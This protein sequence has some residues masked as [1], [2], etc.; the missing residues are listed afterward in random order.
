MERVVEL[1]DQGI[2]T[3]DVDDRTDFINKRGA[4]LL[5]HAPEDMIGRPTFDLL[6]LDVVE[7]WKLRISQAKE[8][9]A[10]RFDLIIRRNDGSIVWTSGTMQ[11][12]YGDDGSYDGAL[13]MFSDITERKAAENSLLESERLYRGLY[14]SFGVG[15]LIGKLLYDEH[16]TPNDFVFHAINPAYESQTG[17]TADR[18]IGKKASQI[19]SHIEPIWIETIGEAVR[20]QRAMS[21]EDY[22]ASLDMWFKGSAS[23]LPGKDLFAI[24]F[25]DVTDRKRTMEALKASEAKYHTLFET[26]HEGLV[27]LDVLRDGDGNATDVRVIEVN[28][29]FEQQSGMK[30]DQLL[31]KK[32]FEVFPRSDAERWMAILKR[33]ADTNEAEVVTEY[34]ELAD[35][36]FE[37]SVYPRGR[38]RMII[39]Y[40][41]IS[42]RKRAEAALK[43]REQLYRTLF[44]N[45]EDAF[46]L[47]EMIYDAHGECVDYWILELNKAW[48]GQTGLKAAD[49]VNKRV[50]ERMPGLEP[51]WYQI[52]GGVARTGISQRFESFNQASGRWYETY[53][54]KYQEDRTGVLFRDITERKRVEKQLAFQADLLDNVHDPLTATDEDFTIT[55]WNRA[56]EVMFGWSAQE[57]VGKVSKDIF[58]TRVPSSSRRDAIEKMLKENGYEGEVYYRRKDGTY[59]LAQARATVLRGPNGEF[60]GTI[61]SFSDITERKKAENALKE[62]EEKYRSLF[63]NMTEMFQILEPIYD[64]SGNVNDFRYIEVNTASETLSRIKKEKMEGRTSKELWGVVEDYWFE[65]LERVLRAGEPEHM[66]NYSRELDAYYDLHAWKASE[67]RVAILFSNI[68]DVKRAQRQVGEERAR[69]Q[70]TLDSLP[71]GVWI[72]DKEGKMVLINEKASQ[73]WGGVAPAATIV[74]EYGAYE[75]W[76]PETRERIEAEDMPLAHAIKGE[77]VRERLLDFERFDGTGGTQVVSASP[78]LDS[79]GRMIGAIAVVQDITKMKDLE[80]D[81]SK[82]N[83]E[84]RRSNAELQQFAYVASHDMQEPLRMVTNYLSLIEKRHGGELTPKVKEYVDIASRS[85]E[86]MRQLV[87]DLLQY[88]R[89]DTQG[90]AFTRVDMN[91]V[92][93]STLM[94][95]KDAV[96]D[97]HATYAIDPLPTV[98]GDELQ[99]KQVMMN[100]ISNAIKFHD[101]SDPRFE[102]SAFKYGTEHVIAVQDNGIGID[103]RFNDKLFHMFSRLHTRD[104]YPG[105]GIGLAISKKIVE[106]HGGRIWVESEVGKGST[107]YFTIP[108][109]G[110]GPGP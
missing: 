6:P 81:L 78:I 55:Y 15:I 74:D 17:F 46:A 77:V 79:K 23:P 11:P 69:L 42:E 9:K 52:Y 103:L 50:S 8:G 26:M 99:L 94:E 93:T 14:D 61:T 32:L 75:A 65:L 80:L 64:E 18:V 98:C 58:Q 38:D 53:A 43:D 109:G 47:L 1:A 110:G 101:S 37:T 12:L 90:K 2:W 3:W 22:N 102:V 105:T 31:G 67:N 48:E 68:T 66:E 27:V 87:K 89:I 91:K 41:D 92:V 29:A 33:A 35:R 62:S 45:T 84:L 71:V 13:A 56:A 88:S 28:D 96:N 85:A 106:R 16:G 7:D 39:F 57:V 63:E 83:E 44:E 49:F 34:L 60:K 72:S 40:R 54:F 5:G 21:V 4:S 70:A 76:D 95:L 97:A 82:T 86:Q 107:F 108:E 100:L 30:R 51:I 19:A 20:T 73:I 10:E 36:W 59:I 104:E 25:E 24:S